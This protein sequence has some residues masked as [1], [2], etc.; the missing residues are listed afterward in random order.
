MIHNKWPVGTHWVSRPYTHQGVCVW[1]FGL[2]CCVTNSSDM[3]QSRGP[4]PHA[5]EQTPPKH[6]E[7][8]EDPW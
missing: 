6:Q 1:D 3:S 5:H 8:Q 4:R 7:N 2:V